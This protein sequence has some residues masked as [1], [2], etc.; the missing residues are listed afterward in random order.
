MRNLFLGLMVGVGVV[1]GA[2]G[3]AQALPPWAGDGHGAWPAPYLSEVR[4]YYGGEDWRYRQWRREE[5]WERWRRHE[6]WRRWNEY[7]RW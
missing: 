1:V 5:A 4:G 7:R 3:A 2:A 6:A